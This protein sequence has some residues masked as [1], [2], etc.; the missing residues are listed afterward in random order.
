MSEQDFDLV[1]VNSPLTDEIGE[2]LS[3]HIIEKGI[4]QVVLIVKSDYYDEISSLVEDDGVITISKPINKSTLWFSL[5]LAK[6]AYSRMKKIQKENVKLVEKLEDIKIVSRA[7]SILISHLNMTEQEA[8]KH[9][10]Q[11]AMDARIRRRAVAER[12]LRTYE[13]K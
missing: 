1:V 12:I 7:K 4:S 10:E 9:I 5:K 13:N 6:A 8:H 3:C 11:E 2:K